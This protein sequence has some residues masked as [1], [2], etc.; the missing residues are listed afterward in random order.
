MKTRTEENDKKYPKGYFL[1]LWMGMCI[2]IFS[3]IGIPIAIISENFAF[4]GI[5]PAIGVSIGL[6]IGQ[7][8][9]NKHEKEG[10]MRPLTKEEKR[11]ARRMLFLGIAVLFMLAILG[12]LFFLRLK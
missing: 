11:G 7:G 8:I 12:V 3:G 1:N 4:I 2:A 5:G 6:A 9:E 10:K